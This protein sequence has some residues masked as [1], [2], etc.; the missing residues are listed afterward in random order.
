M[1]NSREYEWS[2]V[3]VVLSNR[4]VIGIRGIKYKE[5]IEREALYA[6]GKMPHSIQGGNIS[7]EGEI[8]VLQSEL[9]ALIAAGKGSILRLKGLTANISYGDPLDGDSLITDRVEGIYFT[10]SE[11][12]LTQGDKNMEITLPF[13][14]LNVS[15]HV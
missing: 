7:F 1:F 2:D 10:E 6:K 5:T 9:E 14:A 4:D 11:K 15:Y 12:S 3:T 8:T 13:I